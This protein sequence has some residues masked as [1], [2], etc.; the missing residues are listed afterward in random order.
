[1]RIEVRNEK[2]I[3]DGYVN[4]VGRDSRPMI[5]RRSGEKFVEQ[6]VPGVFKRALKSADNIKIL[7]NHDK[8][9]EIGDT[10]TNLKLFEDSIGLRAIAEITDAEVIKKAKEKKLR[11]WSFGFVEKK[12][13]EED[14]NT[15][16]KRRFVE[17]LELKEVSLIDERKNPCYRGTSVYIRADEEEVVE[18]RASETEP[19]YEE[20][21]K[22]SDGLKEYKD[23]IKELGGNTCE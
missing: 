2:V 23:I 8:K 22:L 9:R 20:T 6:M 4:A 1:M 18:E 10:K 5:D 13:S 3:I 19:I 15:G 12:A 16:M 14:T 21:G 11:G 7:L 17:E